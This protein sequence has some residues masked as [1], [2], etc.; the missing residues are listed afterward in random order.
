MVGTRN[1][2]LALAL[3]AICNEYLEVG[4]WCWFDGWFIPVTPTWSI[5]H[6]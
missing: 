2:Y 6:P 1:A 3:T 5:G 4:G